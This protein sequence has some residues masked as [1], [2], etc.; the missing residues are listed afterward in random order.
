MPVLLIG[1]FIL[2]ATS[3]TPARAQNNEA[4]KQKAIRLMNSVEGA[5]PV[6]LDNNKLL[7]YVD[8]IKVSKEGYDVYMKCH[9]SRVRNAFAGTIT[10]IT[11]VDPENYK[12]NYRPYTIDENGYMVFSGQTTMDE[13]MIITSKLK[14]ASKVMFVYFGGVQE[15]EVFRTVPM[16]FTL[17]LGDNPYVL[18]RLPRHAG[19]GFYEA[20][21]TEVEP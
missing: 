5:T 2:V 4:L 16:F 13:T 6:E 3:V 19:A 12:N 7:L 21:K 18:E 10:A 11:F 8:S 9:N 1:A 15:P 17:V 14:P 20:L